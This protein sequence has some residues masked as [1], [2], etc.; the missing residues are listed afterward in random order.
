MVVLVARER[1]TCVGPEEPID[2]PLN[3]PNKSDQTM[4]LMILEFKGT[5]A[6]Q[7]VVQTEAPSPKAT[8]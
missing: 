7:A 1:I 2:Y 5:A 8:L 3:V 6:E 4:N